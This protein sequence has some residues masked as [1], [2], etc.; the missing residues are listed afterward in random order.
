MRRRIVKRWNGEN[1]P[2]LYGDWKWNNAWP[3][4]RYIQILQ[5]IFDNPKC[6]RSEIIAHFYGIPKELG[7]GHIS[8]LFSCMLFD[9]LIDY[10]NSYRYVITEKGKKLLCNTYSNAIDTIGYSMC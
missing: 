10:D 1:K 2:Y 3:S 8:S 6:K 5:Y 7:R 9:D 4:R